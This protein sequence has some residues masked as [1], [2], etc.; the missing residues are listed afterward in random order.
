MREERIELIERERD[1]L[2]GLPEIQ[3]GHLKQVEAGRRLRLTD[4][5]V[6]ASGP[7]CEPK[8]IMDWRINGAAAGFARQ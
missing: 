7:A 2:K 1:R 8:E 5:R 6:G 4:R 3:Q